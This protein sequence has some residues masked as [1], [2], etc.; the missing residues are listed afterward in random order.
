MG[1]ST[2]LQDRDDDACG[3]RWD[4]AECW[5]ISLGARSLEGKMNVS[6]VRCRRLGRGACVCR[7]DDV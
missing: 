5:L 3:R 6:D 4:V 1:R 7:L 2:E